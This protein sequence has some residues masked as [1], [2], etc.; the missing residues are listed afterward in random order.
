M[1]QRISSADPD[2]L[3]RFSQRGLD[4]DAALQAGA[5]ALAAAVGELA[6]AGEPIAG[7]AGYAESLT[8]LVLDWIHLD[9]FAAHVAEGFLACAAAVGCDGTASFTVTD[10]DL[11]RYT[12]VGYADRDT[13]IAEAN[14]LA[15]DLRALLRDGDVTAEDIDA[16]RARTDRG[17]YDPSFAVTFSESI[18]VEGYVHLVGRI[19]EATLPAR[20][21]DEALAAVA[22]L[23]TVLTTALATARPPGTP[24]RPRGLPDDAEIDAAFVHD[25]MSGYDTGRLQA[26]PEATD[27]S[28]LMS[29]TDPPTAIAVDIANARLSPVL[30]AATLV[31]TPLDSND[32]AWLG[33]SGVVTNYATMLARNPDASAQWLAAQPRNVDGATNLSLV[34]H[35]HAERYLDDGRAFARVV[36]NAVTHEDITTRHDSLDAAIA[37]L[38]G[39]DRVLDN[40]H[41]PDALAQGAAADMAY[42]DRLTNL[43]WEQPDLG[44]PPPAS[45]FQLHDFMAEILTEESAAVRVYTALGSYTADQIA[46]APAAGIDWTPG[47]ASD[48]RTDQLRGLGSL[49]G[50]IVTAEANGVQHAAEAELLRRQRRADGLD[51]LVGF[52][53]YVGEFNDL[54][55]L[56]GVSVGSF[57]FP[58]NLSAL[59]R[60]EQVQSLREAG[61]QLD[62]V[63]T[64]A[65]IRDPAAVPETP[66]IDMSTEQRARFLDWAA[67]NYDANDL[68]A[69]EAGAGY[70]NKHLRV[71]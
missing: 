46:Q 24:P 27:L 17:R 63:V 12:H 11:A 44:H 3:A 28:V 62:N 52:V 49:Q 10:A 71:L 16:L 32:P 60:A 41:M 67:H 25:L 8:D 36:E 26:D 9:Q 61:F 14:R 23:G 7:L 22:V 59:G 30:Y 64:L 40:P 66:V 39:P 57:T 42:L 33:H 43:G 56:D 69:L 19:R 5:D 47:D 50:L 2:D 48:N 51:F 70:A 58:Q 29:M 55:A 54:A 18:G 21:D 45:A 20:G 68:H 15:D 35:Q 34:L 1:A 65:T 38:A 4:L 6:G 53:P 31:D 37:V 13:A